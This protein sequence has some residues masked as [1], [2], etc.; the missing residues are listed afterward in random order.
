MIGMK[1]RSTLVPAEEWLREFIPYGTP[2][3]EPCE[4]QSTVGKRRADAMEA[5]L[6]ALRAELEALKADR[7]APGVPERDP[8]RRSGSGS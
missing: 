7:A 2:C 4:D 5:E 8:V 6:A 3:D 1:A